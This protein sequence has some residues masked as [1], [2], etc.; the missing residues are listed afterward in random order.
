MGRKPASFRIVWRAEL[1]EPY[2]CIH[3]AS[4]RGRVHQPVIT[5]RWGSWEKTYILRSIS[6]CCINDPAERV[7]WWD[8]F[9]NVDVPRLAKAK[10]LVVMSLVNEL[11]PVIPY[12]TQ[13]DI[14]VAHY[15]AMAWRGTRKGREDLYAALLADAVQRATDDVEAP[16][17]RKAVQ[18]AVA[19]GTLSLDPNGKL[20]IAHYDFFGLSQT[21]TRDELKKAFRRAALRN[22]PDHGGS[23][24]VMK[25]VNRLRERLEPLASNI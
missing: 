11:A 14:L 7:R 3:L 24:E 4:R 22:H 12:P 2:S 16:L 8:R 17:R 10:G 25:L 21:F 13:I 9:H 18:D 15:M 6:D 19:N 20:E 23:H 1:S 5:R